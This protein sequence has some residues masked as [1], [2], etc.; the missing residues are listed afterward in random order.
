MLNGHALGGGLELARLADFRIAEEHVRLGLPETGLGMVPG[1]SGTQRAG[2]PLRAQVVRRMALGGDVFD[3]EEALRLGLVDEVVASGQG[4]RGRAVGGAD[5][6][7][8]A[9]RRPR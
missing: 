3:A 7:A 6:G 2:A 8:R 5:R 9:G 1:W 4:L